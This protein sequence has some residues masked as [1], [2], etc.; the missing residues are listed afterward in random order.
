MSKS[1]FFDN[2][3]KLCSADQISDFIPVNPV[4]DAHEKIVEQRV[5][6]LIS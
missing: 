3:V 1:V 5:V 6:P 2:A 4:V